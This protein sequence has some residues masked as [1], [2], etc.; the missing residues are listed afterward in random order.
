VGQSDK[1]VLAETIVTIPVLTLPSQLNSSAIATVAEDAAKLAAAGWPPE[2]HI[3]FQPLGFVRPAGVVFLS[4]LMSWLHSQGTK[5]FLR[6][7]DLNT[8]WRE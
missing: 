2:L 7:I 8:S 1:Q 6:N 4:N 5:V 3:D